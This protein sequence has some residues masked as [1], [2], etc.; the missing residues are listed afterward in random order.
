[1]DSGHRCTHH[2]ESQLRRERTGPLLAPLIDVFLLYGVVFG[3]TEK[4]IVSWPGV[5]ASQADQAYNL[6]FMQSDRAVGALD[7]TYVLWMFVLV[8]PLIGL[9]ILAF[10]WIE[11]IAAKR[12]PRLWPNGA[13]GA[14]GRGRA[15]RTAGLGSHRG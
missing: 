6:P 13:K 14:K 15:A 12:S 3:P 1:M 4:T 2:D 9:T 8:W 5:L 10:G 7:T 11:D